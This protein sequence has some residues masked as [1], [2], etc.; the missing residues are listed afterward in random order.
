MMSSVAEAVADSVSG[1]GIDKV[2]SRVF[3]VE[4]AEM[5]RRCH[6][7]QAVHSRVVQRVAPEAACADG[8]S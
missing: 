5:M 2:D 1:T 7:D 6:C 8:S 3:A 4:G